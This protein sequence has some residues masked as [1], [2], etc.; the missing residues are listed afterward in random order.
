VSRRFLPRECLCQLAG[1]PL[2][3]GMRRDVDPNEI[4]PGD[5]NDNETV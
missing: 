5:P 4:P 1:H 3:C 2:R